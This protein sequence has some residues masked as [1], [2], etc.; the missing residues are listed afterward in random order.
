MAFSLVTAYPFW[1]IIFCIATG[2]LYA[3]ILYKWKPNDE[4]K[5]QVNW[6]LFILRMSAVTLIAFLLLSP[7]IK[8]TRNRTEK[9]M[10]ILAMDNT[11]SMVVGK[12]SALI[13]KDFMSEYQK[14]AD[15]LSAKFDV[16]KYTFGDK[17]VAGWQS[18]FNGKQTDMGGLFSE[19]AT[20]YTNRNLAAMVI[21]GDGITTRG[22]DPIFAAEKEKYSIY[23][24]ALGDTNQQK[25]LLIARINYN[26]IAYLG[27]SFPL[28][29]IIMAHKCSGQQSRLT[30]FSGEEQVFSKEVF[31]GSDIQSLT[32][33]ITLNAS[34]TGVQRFRIHL[35]PVINEVTISNNTREVFIE[36]MDGRQK[37]LILSSSPHPDIAALTSAMEK[38][39]NYTVEQ[40]FVNEFN[41]NIEQYNLVVLHQLPSISDA[42]SQLITKLKGSSVPVLYLL[43]NQSN[44]QAFN[45]IQAGLMI[46]PSNTTPTSAFPI[47]NDE[48]SLFTANREIEDI[49]TEF[50]PLTSP[51]GQYKTSPSVHVLF[52]QKIG[53][54]STT[55]PL[56]AFNQTLDQKSAFVA[57]EGIWRWRLSNYL[58]TGNHEAFDGLISK[59]VQYLALKSD[60]S[61]FRVILDNYFTENENVE[62]D[63]ELYNDSYELINEPNVA[64]TIVNKEGKQYPFTFSRSGKSYF[65]N[66][67][68][69]PPGDY[70]LKASTQFNGKTFEK[71]ASFVITSINEE[72]LNTV[73]DHTLMFNLAKQHQGEMYR[74][75]DLSKLEQALNSRE[76]FVTVSYTQK[77]YTDLVNMFWVFFLITALISSEWFIRKYMGG[78]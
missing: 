35:T 10:V 49:I 69:F 29:V 28:E 38:N 73:A 65:L 45:A 57:G 40:Q 61:Q 26:R 20:R 17:V 7:L 15:D 31:I 54:I 48:F 18:D 25:D 68:S 23:T 43:G 14:L 8:T 75:G 52:Y 21:A 55:L 77:K 67:G 63:A 44:L 33:P 60:K 59:I 36:V 41:G 76:D 2:A 50:P 70:S 16:V 42:A 5:R 53:S 56:I 6:L 51:F 22:T 11:G 72:L 64:V 19:V 78:Y 39:L 66:A 46:P 74:P 47:L 24:V 12:D 4:Y 3:W 13:R 34:K 9:P 37:I 30:V 32:V 71:S 1:F 58:K 62:I 27:N